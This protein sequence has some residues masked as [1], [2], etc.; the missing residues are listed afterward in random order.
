[1]VGGDRRTPTERLRG[2]GVQ[3]PVYELDEK[4]LFLP[5]AFGA[6]FD[7]G[8]YWAADHSMVRRTLEHPQGSSGCRT[9][10]Q[11]SAQESGTQEFVLSIKGT[12]GLHMVSVPEVST[13]VWISLRP[14]VTS[15][16]IRPDIDLGDV[17]EVWSHC[18]VF[19]LP[20]H[21]NG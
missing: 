13:S 5:L 4:V 12:R 11:L 17:R 1:M 9:L 3:R 15:V 8:I 2:K 6:R 21:S 19:G 18:P 14:E 7:Y 20:C 16:R 10:R